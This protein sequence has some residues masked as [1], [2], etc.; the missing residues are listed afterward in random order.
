MRN[1]RGLRVCDE[2]GCYHTV[3]EGFGGHCEMHRQTTR[4]ISRLVCDIRNRLGL[5]PPIFWDEEAAQETRT[6]LDRKLREAENRQLWDTLLPKWD[7]VPK[8]SMPGPDYL[9]HA[10]VGDKTVRELWESPQG[11]RFVLLQGASALQSLNFHDP[12]ELDSVISALQVASERLRA[13]GKQGEP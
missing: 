9:L 1:E 3:P 4:V 11:G 12:D 2:D 13:F 6:V 8:P 10:T 7:A 5:A